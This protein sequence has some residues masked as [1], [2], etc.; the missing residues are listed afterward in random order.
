M[1]ASEI[2]AHIRDHVTTCFV[3]SSPMAT[4]KTHKME[5]TTETTR[6]KVLSGNLGLG[7]SSSFI[8][9][10]E[11]DIRVVTSFVSFVFMARY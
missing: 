8:N 3:D 4:D 6:S 7:N 11:A 10:S 5:K 2:E 1:C 9:F